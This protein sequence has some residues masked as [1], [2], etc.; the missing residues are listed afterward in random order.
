[1]GATRRH[2]TAI[3]S[4]LR[5]PELSSRQDFGTCTGDP[6]KGTMTYHPTTTAF[7]AEL[8]GDRG[9]TKTMRLLGK[10]GNFFR[11]NKSRHNQ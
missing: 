3:L 9:S 5:G 7:I 10:N 1:M 8:T 2:Q 6:I 11:A 4:G